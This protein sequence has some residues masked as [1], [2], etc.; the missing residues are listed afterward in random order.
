MDL[1]LLSCH[2]NPVR[3]YVHKIYW[4]N[5]LTCLSSLSPRGEWG[6]ERVLSI[7]ICLALVWLPLPMC[8]ILSVSFPFLPFSSMFPSVYLFFFFLQ[9]P[10]Q[11]L[12]RRSCCYPFWGHVLSIAIF[13][14]WYM[15]FVF[16]S[17]LRHYITLL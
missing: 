13:F 5:W 4:Y 11:V 15:V 9:G 12:S 1:R 3:Y 7:L 2:K 14:S 6:H 16:V 8:W 10:S 17:A